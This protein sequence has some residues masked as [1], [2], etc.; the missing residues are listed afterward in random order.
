M[1]AGVVNACN[2]GRVLNIFL[3]LLQALMV[4]LDGSAVIQR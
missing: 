1:W 2:V 4:L 3:F